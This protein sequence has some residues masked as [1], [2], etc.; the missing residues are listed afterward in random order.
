MALSNW[1]VKL[2]KC[3]AVLCGT[4]EH[5]AKFSQLTDDDGVMGGSISMSSIKVVSSVALF[6]IMAAFIS[7]V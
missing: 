4:A 5:L 7:T 6:V 1:T 2:Q 3:H